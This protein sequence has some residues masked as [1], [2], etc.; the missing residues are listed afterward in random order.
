[1]RPLLI[2][3]LLM[4]AVPV[5][6]DW[7]YMR[8]GMTPDEVTKASSNATQPYTSADS[9]NVR[10]GLNATPQLVAPGSAGDYRFRAFFYFDSAG[11]LTAVDLLGEA[12]DARAV[13]GDLRAKYGTPEAEHRDGISPYRRVRGGRPVI[14]HSQSRCLSPIRSARRMSLP[15]PRMMTCT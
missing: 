5:H 9:R 14:A 8:W 4:L 15:S 10:P 1:M 11:K 6:G 12:G 2:L 7:Q 3:T 13:L